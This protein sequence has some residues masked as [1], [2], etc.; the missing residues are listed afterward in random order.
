MAGKDLGSNP[1]CSL[2]DRSNSPR[3]SSHSCTLSSCFWRWSRILNQKLTLRLLYVMLEMC[4][5]FLPRPST[6]LMIV[7][8]YRVRDD[9]LGTPL[10]LLRLSP[11]RH[12]AFP[13]SVNELTAGRCDGSL[14]D[15]SPFWAFLN[16]FPTP[17]R[18]RLCVSSLSVAGTASSPPQPDSSPPI[19]TILS[20]PGSDSGCLP[21][22]FPSLP[23]HLCA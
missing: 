21:P 7:W 22:P 11:W 20:F 6:D 3:L 23:P 12:Q 18:P 15:D 4:P 9:P 13:Q 2:G 8:S 16:Q 10:L 19:L 17:P 1:G 14:W 5:S